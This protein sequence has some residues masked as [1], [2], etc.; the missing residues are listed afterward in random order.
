MSSTQ[1]IFI[2]GVSATGISVFES[3]PPSPS[4]RF[5]INCNSVTIDEGSDGILLNAANRINLAQNNVSLNSTTSS[6]TGIRILG[7][8]NC[9]LL[10]NTVTGNS[11][12]RRVELEHT[13]HLQIHLQ[14]IMQI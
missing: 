6:A 1:H 11:T 10:E 12:A 2:N 7:S 3:V 14:I 5:K 13:F 9:G 8:S 4:R